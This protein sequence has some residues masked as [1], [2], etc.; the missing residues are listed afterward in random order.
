MEPQA[1]AGTGLLV[2][3]CTVDESTHDQS[4]LLRAMIASEHEYSE[5]EGQGAERA[6]E[7]D[8]PLSE[9]DG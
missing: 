5:G 1:Q 3:A 8:G 6:G 7:G 9:E 4:Q 2:P